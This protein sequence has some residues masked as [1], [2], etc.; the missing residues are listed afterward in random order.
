MN[1]MNKGVIIG[2]RRYRIWRKVEEINNVLEG[3]GVKGLE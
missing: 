2:I 3:I 1:D